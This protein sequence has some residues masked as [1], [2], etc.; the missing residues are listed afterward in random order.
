MEII[1]KQI[2]EIQAKIDANINNYSAIKDL[3]K[4]KEALENEL[5]NKF[6]RWEYLSE[7]DRI[8]KEK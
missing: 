5:E 7:I 2:E 6:S 1:A 8:S 3:Y 4:E